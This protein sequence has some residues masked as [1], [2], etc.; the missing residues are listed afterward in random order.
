VSKNASA[1]EDAS[2][3]TVAEASSLFRALDNVPAL[4]LAV[5]GGPDSTALMVL[6]ARW[7]AACEN[8]PKLIAVTVDHGLRAESKRE[9]A[10]VARLAK[11]LGLAHRTLR[12]EGR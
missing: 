1:A 10:A 5:S 6:A 3:I 7:R 9:A 4:I 12:W 8:P 11:Q 2:P